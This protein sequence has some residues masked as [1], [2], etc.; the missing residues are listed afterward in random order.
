MMVSLQ[1]SPEAQTLRTLTRTGPTISKILM[2]KFK[3]VAMT[4]TK[5]RSEPAREAH[6]PS[7]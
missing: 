6:R 5:K 4:V 1:P 3:K 7:E 2:S